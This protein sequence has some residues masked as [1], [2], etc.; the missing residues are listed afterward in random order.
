MTAI[1]YRALSAW[2][3]S[4]PS[5]KI[6]TGES[7]CAIV[8]RW[9][10]CVLRLHDKPNEH[11]QFESELRHRAPSVP[12]PFLCG[13]AVCLSVC[14]GHEWRG[15]H[16][17]SRFWFLIST[18]SLTLYPSDLIWTCGVGA[19]SNCPVVFTGHAFLES[20]WA[21]GDHRRLQRGGSAEDDRWIRARRALRWPC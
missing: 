9:P 18:I 15:I 5:D 20:R 3:C 10:K 14:G 12:A 17:R 13:R 11:S 6:C 4:A 1:A 7:M 16:S 19:N 8:Q 21:C 2:S